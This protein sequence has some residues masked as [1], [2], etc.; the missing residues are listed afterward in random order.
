MR[1]IYSETEVYHTLD[2]VGKG[3]FGK[4][5]KCWR[6]S[7][8]ELVA[9]KMMK[10]DVLR[11]QIIKNEL[12]LT[13][14]LSRTNIKASHI[15]QFHEAFRD[16]THHYLVFELLEKNL[17]QLLKENGF[18][19]MAIR[20]IRTITCQIIK[21]LVKLKELAIIHADLKPE[22]VMVVDH[23]RH[24]FRVKLI[25]FGS[26]S[27]LNE[28]R[29]VKEPYIQSRFYRSPEILLGLPFCE[30]VDMWSLGCVM[31]E[32][33]LGWPLYPG[34][35]E[36]DQVCYICETQGLPGAHLLNAASKAHLFFQLTT[37]RGENHWQL[38]SNRQRPP[39]SADGRT[40]GKESTD[41][42]KYILSSLDQLETMEF[43]ER[44]PEN[45]DVAAEVVDRHSMVQL[46]KQMLTLDSH[47]RIGPSA[48]SQHPFI[49]MQHLRVYPDYSSYC[50]KATQAVRSALILDTAPDKD[51]FWFSRPPNAGGGQR[52][53]YA[54]EEES[55]Q[56]CPQD[57]HHHDLYNVV[58]MLTLFHVDSI[59][60]GL[61]AS[62]IS[63]P[64]I[65][66]FSN[67]N[68]SHLRPLPFGFPTLPQEVQFLHLEPEGYS[69]DCGQWWPAWTSD[70][71][72][73]GYVPW[74]GSGAYRLHVTVPYL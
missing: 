67:I 30:K 65:C 31:A 34:D 54:K 18:M 40:Q 57:R 74:R 61:S 52:Y 38:R 24:P 39:L 10:I 51:G 19:P 43:T 29:F 26:A 37:D 36:F 6:G 15:V 8:G 3:T 44:D 56:R 7:D 23:C 48:A 71:A 2:V 1:D 53:L 69:C 60:L 58:G 73:L 11:N 13:G 45:E 64:V 47:Q 68:L 42:R 17:Y 41:R 25:D 16:Q 9:V 70:L 32:L 49:S 50:E 14:A 62:T 21:A 27:I 33:F 20:N 28:V 66:L 35:S 12:K 72:Y 46:L 4:V 5:S 55:P 63:A 22:N 59:L